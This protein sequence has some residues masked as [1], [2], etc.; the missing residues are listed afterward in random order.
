MYSK[1]HY[2]GTNLKQSDSNSFNEH[3]PSVIALQT[4]IFTINKFHPWASNK[5]SLE[6]YYNGKVWNVTYPGN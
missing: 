3:V 2:S 1:L 6:K 5:W 4:I